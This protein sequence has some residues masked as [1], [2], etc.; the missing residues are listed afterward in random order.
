MRVSTD[1]SLGE[2]HQLSKQL[3]RYIQ[4]VPCS[5]WIMHRAFRAGVSAWD[6]RSTTDIGGR[7]NCNCGVLAERCSEWCIY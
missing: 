1:V 5:T 7:V 4:C 6:F 3:W 2:V